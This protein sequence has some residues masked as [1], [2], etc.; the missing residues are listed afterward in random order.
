MK[1]LRYLLILMGLWIILVGS[2]GSWSGVTSLTPYAYLIIGVC[3]IFPILFPPVDRGYPFVLFSAALVLLLALRAWGGYGLEQT[4]LQLLVMETGAIGVTTLLATLI[5]A[6]LKAVQDLF[7]SLSIN[8]LQKHVDTFDEGQQAIYRE[9]RWARR[10]QRR[11]A[12]LAISIN[13]DSLETLLGRQNKMTLMHRLAQEAQSE[14]WHT[15]ALN[16]LAQLLVN[17]LGD[18]A[19]ITRRREHFVVLTE[20]EGE[21]ATS[22]IERLRGLS[23]AELGIKLDIG[24]AIFPDEAVTFEALLQQAEALMGKTVVTPTPNPS[25][26]IS[27]ADTSKSVV[28]VSNRQEIRATDEVIS[29]V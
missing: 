10:Y 6:Q 1:Y 5:G 19:I 24:V 21:Q 13:T 16:R 27:V 7:E 17:E 14:I 15:Y 23:G 26:P 8:K 29:S 12:L 11:L 20:A 2:L 28:M 3:A 18:N 4:D 25:N 9:V 22:T